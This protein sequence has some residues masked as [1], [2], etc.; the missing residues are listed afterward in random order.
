MHDLERSFPNL[1]KTG[2]EITSD[3]DLSYN[4]I[5]WAAG[6]NTRWWEPAPSPFAYWPDRVRPREYST[7][8]FIRVFKSIGYEVCESA[9]HE[10]GFERIAI[11]EKDGMPQHMARQ[12]PNGLWTSKCGDDE[13]IT[14]TL[15]G[16]ENSDY[17]KVS[18]IMK[19]ETAED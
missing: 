11:Y 18:V 3:K 4:C 9:Q 17:G 7:A 16:L 2:Y 6:C 14:H 15:E 8:A 19:R 1:R 5:A 12:L 13:D 10:P